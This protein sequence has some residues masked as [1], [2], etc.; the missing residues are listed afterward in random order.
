MRKSVPLEPCPMERRDCAAISEDGFCLALSDIDY[1][2][3]KSCPFYKSAEQNAEEI[4]RSCF[5]LARLRRYDLVRKC[6]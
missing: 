1:G 3:G 2:P 4:A 6:I 5:R